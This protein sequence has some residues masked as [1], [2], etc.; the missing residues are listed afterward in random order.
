MSFFCQKP[1]LF[2]SSWVVLTAAVAV[3]AIKYTPYVIHCIQRITLPHP[4]VQ[5]ACSHPGT[6]PCPSHPPLLLLIPIPP[7]GSFHQFRIFSRL[8]EGRFNYLSTTSLLYCI[9]L[10][11]SYIPLSAILKDHAGQFAAALKRIFSD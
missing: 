10:T 8:C 4:L 9:Y 2:L 7:E 6:F 3:I 5:G 11:L 1:T